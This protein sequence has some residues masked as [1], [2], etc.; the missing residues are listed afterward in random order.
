LKEREAGR[1][2]PTETLDALPP[3]GGLDKLFGK[4]GMDRA[5]MAR[6]APRILYS[7][8]ALTS[9]GFD[10]IINHVREGHHI[11]GIRRT[12]LRLLRMGEP[13]RAV[14]LATAL[15]GR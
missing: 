2:D 9:S 10:M 5:V 6:M 13:L 1:D 4:P 15:V 3:L 8:I 14:K 11:K 12:V 7:K